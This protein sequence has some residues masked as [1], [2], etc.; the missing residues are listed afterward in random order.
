MSE[1]TSE[2]P[3]TGAGGRRIG[4]VIAVVLAVLVAGAVVFGVLVFR[5]LNRKVPS[6]PSLTAHPDSSL[7]G[8][9]AYL[10]DRDHCVWIISAS[11]AGSKQV[12]CLPPMDV[13]KAISL[14]KETG[15]QLVWLNDGRLEVTM[16]RMADPKGPGL[17]TGWQKVVDVRTGKVTDTPAAEV[18]SSPNLGTR[19]TVSPTGARVAFTSRSDNGKVKITLSDA[20]GT[21]TLLSA[22]GPTTSYWLLAAFWSPD[23]KWIAADDGRILVITPGNPPVTRVLTGDSSNIVFGTDAPG[24]ARFAITKDDLLTATK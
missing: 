2:A 4:T 21:R 22:Q 5:E 24:L 17:T 16:F 18:P 1:T 15:P 14:G 23:Y 12:L 7:H 19:P 10:S 20:S 6:F 11:G 8:T 13:S 9:V 3:R